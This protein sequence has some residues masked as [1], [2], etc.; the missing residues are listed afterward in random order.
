MLKGNSGEGTISFFPMPWKLKFFPK[1]NLLCSW[2]KLRRGKRGSEE[3]KESNKKQRGQEGGQDK[4]RYIDEGKSE[5]LRWGG[6][7][8]TE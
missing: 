5:R 1:H 7:K 8:G 3:C 4:K 2:R 6:G